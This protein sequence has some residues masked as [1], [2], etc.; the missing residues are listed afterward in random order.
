MAEA[1]PLLPIFTAIDKGLKDAL[2]AIEHVESEIE[3]LEWRL[4]QALRYFEQKEGDVF[5]SEWGPPTLMTTGE[6]ARPVVPLPA[7]PEE[8]PAPAKEV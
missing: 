1:N 8:Q 3:R 7:P 4:D 2:D 5:P 6:F